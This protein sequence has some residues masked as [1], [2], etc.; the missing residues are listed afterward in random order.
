MK[1]ISKVINFLKAYLV[2]MLILVFIMIEYSVMF[3]IGAIR[4]FHGFIR[5]FIHFFNIFR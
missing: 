4:H 5:A 3:L 2:I 1:M